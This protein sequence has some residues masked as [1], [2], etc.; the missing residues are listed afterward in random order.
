MSIPVVLPV[1]TAPTDSSTRI[2]NPRL[3][4]VLRIAWIVLAVICVGNYLFVAV[5]SI[6]EDIQ[7]CDPANIQM[8]TNCNPFGFNPQAQEQFAA[9]VSHYPI[10][11]S[12]LEVS[13]ILITFMFFGVGL[14]LFVRRSDDLMALLVSLTMISAVSWFP[15]T[16]SA[17]LLTL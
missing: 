11:Y 17:I 12:G 5:P 7:R 16:P 1:D 6:W 10:F 13:L 8:K 9:L 3:L 14:L 2:T 4:T 15:V